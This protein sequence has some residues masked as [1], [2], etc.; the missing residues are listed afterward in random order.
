M[1][2]DFTKIISGLMNI[3]ISS[4]PVNIL[5]YISWN[6]LLIIYYYKSVTFKNLFTK[7]IKHKK[8]IT[9]IRKAP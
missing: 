6:C 2:K 5:L 9:S 7:D 4:M 8:K 1:R 3:N